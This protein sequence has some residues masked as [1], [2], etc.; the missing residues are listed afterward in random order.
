M[1]R[2]KAPTPDEREVALRDEPVAGAP[3]A[4]GPRDPAEYA[5]AD[6][7]GDDD[8][9]DDHPGAPRARA[10]VDRAGDDPDADAVDAA[11]AHP[12]TAGARVADLLQRV[13]SLPLETVA[14]VG[15]L[16]RR[17]WRAQRG[18]LRGASAGPLFMAA[19]FAAELAVGARLQMMG[20]H[21]NDLQQTLLGR[22]G[23]FLVLQQLQVLGAYLVVGTVVGVTGALA[24]SLWDRALRRRVSG[25]WRFVG[26]L[27]FSVLIELWR[28]GVTVIRYPQLFTDS[29]YDKGGFRRDLQVGL[30]DVVP[31]AVLAWAGWLLLALFLLGPALAPRSRRWLTHLLRAVPAR[32][33]RARRPAAVAGAVGGLTLALAAPFLLHRNTAVADEPQEASGWAGVSAS[34]PGAPPSPPS[35]PTGKPPNVLILAVD[36]LRAD[37]VGPTHGDVAPHLSRLAAKAVVFDEAHVTIPRTF[38]S[39]A[40]LL[41]GRWPAHHGIRHMFPPATERAAVGPLLPERMAARGLQTA[42][43]SDF[44]GEIFSRLGAGFATRDVPPF[45]MKVVLSQAGFNLHPFIAPYVASRVGHRLFPALAAA[46]ENADPDRLADRVIDAV[47]RLSERGPFFVTAFFS[48]PHFPYA[49][50]DPYYRRFTRPGYR[51]RYRYHKPVAALGNQDGELS[52]ED[53]D[54]I[55]GLYDGAVAAVDDAIGR[56]LATLDRRGLAGDTIVVILADHGENL[57]EPGN[58][59]GH[60]EHLHGDQALHIPL[61]IYDPVHRFPAHRVPGIVR[62]V[63]VAP[64]LAALAGTTIEGAD[65]VDLRPLLEGRESTLGLEAYAETELWLVPEGPGFRPDER[66]PYPPLPALVTLAPDDDIVIDP[67]LR[68]VTIAAKHRAIRTDRWK[69]IYRPTRDG[70]RWSLYDVRADT[71]ERQDL[72]P[73]QPEV[74]AA[75]QEKLFRWM[76]IDGSTVEAGFVVPPADREG[77]P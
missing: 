11:P 46:P 73:S 61:V 44:S 33:R 34:T 59:M 58:G 77:A 7:Y 75:L 60:G 27:W 55:R 22:F 25:A 15:W 16:T 30:T 28:L 12:A 54:Q 31:Q 51:G 38:P 1:A 29:L 63:D 53:R 45:D 57:Y 35:P 3:R 32:V 64:T 37:R 56:V 70:V 5:E 50:P 52:D 67:A 20:V 66:L 2:S 41:S 36:S 69:A 68:D 24:L 13:A 40:T 17:L 49:A 71:D 6:A 21:D 48:T 23:R 39:W 72:A 4:D 43:V 76:M 65:G 26:V 42:V 74:L 62:D 47:E 9:L 18:L 10:G 8:E 14:G 19:L